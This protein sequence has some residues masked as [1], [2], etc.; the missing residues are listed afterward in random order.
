VSA[1]KLVIFGIGEQAE[2]ADFLYTHD[3]DYE[4]VAFTADASYCRE[5]EFRGR[6][7]VAF[8]TVL[9]AYPP[10]AFSL[11]I[12]VGYSK[13]NKLRRQ[14]FD[15]AREAGYVLASYVS[16]RIHQWPDFA[17]GQNCLILEENNIQ[18]FVS[19]GDNV[20]LWSGNHIGHHS[21]IADDSFLT[22][23]V[24]VSGGVQIGRGCFIGVNA[25]LRDHITLGI[26]VLVGASAYVDRDLE[27][28]SVFLP[29]KST[30]KAIPSHRLRGI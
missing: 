9:A 29:P 2:V 13:M 5:P 19:I 14:Y 22:S 12:A 3:S 6:P 28:F 16:S 7:L 26:E 25:T 30:L 1:K 20:T 4:V 18:P 8:E 11:F 17:C 10:S 24:V 15:L 21:T 23:H 27:D